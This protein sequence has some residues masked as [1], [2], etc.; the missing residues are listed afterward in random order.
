[1]THAARP[2]FTLVEALASLVVIASIGGLAG[3]LLF[4]GVEGYRGAAQASHLHS[5]LASAFDRVDRALREIP[6][7]TGTALADIT[8]VSASSIQWNGPGGA[9]LLSLSGGNL[10]L[11]MDGQAAQPI[12]AD[13]TSLSIRCFDENNSLLAANL[14]P[15]ASD[16][17]RRIEVSVAVQRGGLS[18]SLRT[19][20]Y[21]RCTMEGTAP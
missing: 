5:E 9:C 16:A 7:R 18:D 3:T 21:L 13:T 11:A 8:N 2:A 4:R 14:T 17:V 12:L 1:M 15:P 6:A 19:R 20:V 10:M